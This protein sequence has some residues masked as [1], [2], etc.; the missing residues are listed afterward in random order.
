MNQKLSFG[1]EITQMLRMAR[2]EK[3]RLEEEKRITQEIE[4]QS[5]LNT[6]IDEDVARR[7]ADIQVTATINAEKLTNLYKV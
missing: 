1:D 3:F 4:L 5:Y 7:V 2:R 6:L